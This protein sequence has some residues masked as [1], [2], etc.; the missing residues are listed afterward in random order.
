[1]SESEFEIEYAKL[2][3]LNLE[4]QNK[5]QDQQSYIRKLKGEIRML[6]IRV[7]EAN[8]GARSN[9]YIAQDLYLDKLKL[10]KE[11][12]LLKDKIDSLVEALKA[13]EPQ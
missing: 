3:A 5:I 1:M 10:E 12:S 2:L 11:N 6:H 7:R 13:K 9:I 8:R 4:A